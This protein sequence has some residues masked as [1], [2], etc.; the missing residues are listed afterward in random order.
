MNLIGFAG[1]IGAGK[2]FAARRFADR[3]FVVVKFAGPLKAMLAAF[4]REAGLSP[5][6]IAARIEGPLKELADP[7]APRLDAALDAAPAVMTG[8]LV[9]TGIFGGDPAAAAALAEATR[10]SLRRF[11][12]EHWRGGEYRPRRMMQT[13]GGEWGRATQGCDFWVDCWE[14]EAKAKRRAGGVVADDVRYANEAAR[15]RAMGGRVILI[16]R[17]SAFATLA[18]R[19]S[20]RHESEAL[21]FEPD[22]IVVNRGDSGFARAIDGLAD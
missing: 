1:R 21:D 14:A 11:V 5:A 12:G 2:S 4:Y 16:R 7:A 20:G 9:A 18:A 6:D 19:E 15:I 17:P 13:L 8:S 22:A 3:G 10:E